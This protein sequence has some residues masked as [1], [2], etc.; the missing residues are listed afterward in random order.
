MMNSPLF[1]FLGFFVRALRLGL[2]FLS[3]ITS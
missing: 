3:G 2:G 1:H